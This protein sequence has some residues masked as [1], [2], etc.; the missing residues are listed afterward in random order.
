[1]QMFSQLTRKVKVSEVW[2]YRLCFSWICQTNLPHYSAPVAGAAQRSFIWIRVTQLK[3]Y[4]PRK[5]VM[6]EI[7]LGTQL[8][9]QNIT[10][11]AMLQLAVLICVLKSMCPDLQSGETSL[12]VWSLLLTWT[13]WDTEKFWQRQS[14]LWKG[15]PGR[16]W[17]VKP[18]IPFFLGLQKSVPNH[19]STAAVCDYVA[20]TT[21]EYT[22]YAVF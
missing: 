1:M 8:P 15:W 13:L 2:S 19:F 12:Q 16:S 4:S 9:W 21:G 11:N 5:I 14:R 22:K 18:S 17:T 20:N 3:F 10:S 7:C 6:N